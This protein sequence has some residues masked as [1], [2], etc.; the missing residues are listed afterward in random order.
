MAPSEKAK[1]VHG[2]VAKTIKYYLTTHDQNKPIQLIGYVLFLND[3]KVEL[4]AAHC[5]CRRALRL[6][7]S[8]PGDFGELLQD[9]GRRHQN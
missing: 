5:R 7:K 9:T 3:G 4:V 2:Q 8:L 1:S 6:L